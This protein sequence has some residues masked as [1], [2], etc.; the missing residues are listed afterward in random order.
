[1]NNQSPPITMKKIFSFLAALCLASVS[2]GQTGTGIVL[3]TEASHDF[4]G[5]TVDSTTTF[6]LQLQNTVGTAQTVTLRA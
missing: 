2:W 4:G 1:M 3:L 6:N 5:T